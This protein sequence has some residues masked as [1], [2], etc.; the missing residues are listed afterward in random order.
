MENK[1]TPMDR[2]EKVS[3]K[4]RKLLK[5]A[6]TTAPLIASLR[7]EQLLAQAI[8][9]LNC[10]VKTDD[11]VSPDSIANFLPT[12]DTWVRKVGIKKRQNQSQPW[13][14]LLQDNGTDYWLEEDNTGTEL[15]FL[16]PQEEPPWWD[17]NG[18]DVDDYYT[19][20]YY[21]PTGNVS[22]LGPYPVIT[23]NATGNNVTALNGTCLCSVN[24]NLAAQEGVDCSLL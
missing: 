18:N 23:D 13:V 10:A 15:V 3:E 2:S 5:A 14:Y 7:S 17:A 20:V 6:A 19:L 11:N 22:R 16:D 4:R 8:G 9:S 21:D 24:P 1:S 12:Q